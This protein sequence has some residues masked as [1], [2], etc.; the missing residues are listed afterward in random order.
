ME[1]GFKDV[2]KNRRD[3]WDYIEWRETVLVGPPDSTCRN[4][5]FM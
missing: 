1:K 2:E 3:V 4:A 5:T